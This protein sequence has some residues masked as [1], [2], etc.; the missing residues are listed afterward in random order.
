[1]A[2][3]VQVIAMCNAFSQVGYEVTLLLPIS[4]PK[5]DNFEFLKSRYNVNYKF[6]LDFYNQNI[7]FGKGLGSLY[8]IH[9]LIS[10]YEGGQFFLRD[11]LI[12]TL[13]IVRKQRVI[14]ELHNN[15]LHNSR[16]LDRIKKL[17]FSKF[18]RK[19]EMIAII[20]ISE[21]L[22]SSW[23]NIGLPS[24]KIF[25]LHDAVSDIVFKNP[26]SMTDVKN[27]LGL[28][29]SR[30]YAVYVGNICLDRGI[31][32]IISLAEMFIDYNF[33]IVGGPVKL[34]SYYGTLC[35]DKGIE[36]IEFKGFVPHS[37]VLTY[38]YAADI[39]IGVW[40]S[41]I[42][43][44]DYCSPLKLFEYMACGKPI[45]CEGYKSIKEVL[46]DKITAHLANP[47]DLDSLARAFRFAKMS[48][49]KKVGYNAQELVFKEFTWVI[50]ANKIKRVIM[51][52]V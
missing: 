1:M 16:F 49:Y 42:S 17:I 3:M 32:K 34:I 25:A 18:A 13:L 5:V 19:P 26:K 43:T 8:G 14:S 9:K 47:D 7:N 36:N 37:E 11:P 45:V 4:N 33:L 15:I 12:S 31:E 35:K 21:S 51:K 27:N 23:Q 44:M 30:K 39:L 20:T 10:K 2:N 28:E 22:K 24:E 29:I 50:R 41:A 48:E 6:E 52:N 40:S 38:L 46:D